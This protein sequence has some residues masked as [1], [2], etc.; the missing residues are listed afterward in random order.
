MQQCAQ[1]YVQHCMQC[2]WRIAAWDFAGWARVALD[3]AALERVL[4]TKEL[5]AKF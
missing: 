4:A 3:L 1:N 5:G 2:A